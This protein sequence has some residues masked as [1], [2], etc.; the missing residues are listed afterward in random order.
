VVAGCAVICA[1]AGC[2]APTSG[3]VTQLTAVPYDLMS[4][5][6]A[7]STEAPV[8]PEARPLVYLVRE[9]VLV[10]VRASGVAG[11]DV[12]TTL[13]A[14]LAELTEGPDEEARD[15]GLSS[16]LGPDAV[17]TPDRLEGTRAVI[18]VQPGAQAPTA[19]R[20]PLAIGQIVLTVVSVP[21]VESVVFTAKGE[22]IQ[23]P[24]PGGELT[25]R[26]LVASDYTVLTATPPT[27][28]G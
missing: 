26:P 3:Q 28:S 4:P 1:L 9:D 18:D 21:G 23:A 5:P 25:D 12:A 2:G 10:P 20:L 16:A 8:E 19:G 7:A 11:N 6:T 14:L 22:P 13:S 27:S 15:Q 17:I 24:L